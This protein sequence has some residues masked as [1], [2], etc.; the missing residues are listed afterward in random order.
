[1]PDAVNTFTRMNLDL[2]D[3]ALKPDVLRMAYNV[4]IVDLDSN[5]LVITNLKG[6]ESGFTIT[7]GFKAVAWKEYSEVLYLLSYNATTGATELGSYPSP[8]YAN[9]AAGQ[10]ATDPNVYFVYRPFNNLDNGPFST[11]LVG[12]PDENVKL[13]IQQ[14]YDESIN[15]FIISPADKPRMVNAGFR[16]VS[17]SNSAGF[18][19][20][21]SEDRPGDANTNQYVSATVEAQSRQ[22]ISS[23]KVL[24][25]DYDQILTGGKLKAGTYQYIF[26][27]LTED[28]NQSDV[29]GES[30]V[31]AVMP[32]TTAVDM[33][34]EPPTTDTE[35]MVRLDLSNIDTA[36][37][38]F[39]VWVRF[40]PGG[41]T[42]REFLYEFTDPL[43]ITGASMIFSHTG[44]ENIREVSFEEINID[45]PSVQGVKSATQLN[46]YMLLGGIK[47]TDQDWTAYKAAAQTVTV[48]V[49]NKAST[50]LSYNGLN[51]GY[52][53][54][55]NIY[56]SLAYFSAETYPFG[57]VFIM[58]SDM[59]LSP[60]FPVYGMDFTGKTPGSDHNTKGL[61]RFPMADA[62][63]YPI[64]ADLGGAEGM[65]LRYPVFDINNIPQAIRDQTVGFFFVRGQ[66][67]PDKITQG[68][69]LPTLK[70]PPVEYVNYEKYYYSQY[71]A[72]GDLSRYLHVPSV[73]GIL[74]AYKRDVTN[75]NPSEDIYAIINDSNDSNKLNAYMPIFI[76][77][78]FGDANPAGGVYGIDIFPSDYWAFLSGDAIAD[79]ARYASL[80]HRNSISVRQL[81]RTWFVRDGKINPVWDIPDTDTRQVGLYYRFSGNTFYPAEYNIQVDSKFTPSEILSTGHEFT[82]KIHN[83]FH[84]ATVGSSHY[85]FDV[86]LTYNPYFGLKVT[87][88]SFQDSSKV[89]NGPR[90]HASIAELANT[91]QT[92]GVWF[93][94]FGLTSMKGFMVDLYPRTTGMI[95]DINLLYPTVDDVV[96]RQVGKRYLWSDVPTNIVPVYGGDCYIGKVW[97]KLYQSGYRD[98]DRVYEGAEAPRNIDAGT[99]IS[100]VQESEYNLHMR[101]PYLYDVSEAEKRSFFPYQSH[102]DFYRYRRYRLPETTKAGL[103]FISSQHSKNYHK[104]DDQNI[105]LR[106]NF[107]S[108]VMH[109]N[110]HVPNSYANGYRRVVD[111]E[112]YDSSMGEIVDLRAHQGNLIIIFEHGVG[113]TSIEQ[114]I[115]TGSDAGGPIFAK[116]DTV[117]PPAIGYLSHTI[118]CQ[119]IKAI[120]QT[121]S[122]LYGIDRQKGKMW[123]IGV[124]QQGML[125]ISDMEIASWLENNSIVNPILGYD[126]RYREVILSTDNWAICFKEGVEHYIS[127]YGYSA[128]LYT[129][130][131]REFYSIQGA[132]ALRHNSST[133]FSLYGNDPECFVEF[134]INDSAAATKVLDWINILSNETRP[135][136]IEWFTYAGKSLRMLALNTDQMEQYCKVEDGDDALTGFA[137]IYFR[138]KKFV[139]KVPSVEIYNSLQDSWSASGRMRNRVIICRI[140]YNATTPLQLLA[141]THKY[142]ISKS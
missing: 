66:R 78:I 15:V 24:S 141:V 18:D 139:S 91:D 97:R 142:R 120:L 6:T 50:F 39:K 116:P 5:S 65:Y 30:S 46:G 109:T 94:N 38:Y 42:R 54:P 127:F 100:F 130:R 68:L 70:V 36:F 104:I 43:R 60:V 85:S 114:R 77:D 137:K 108:R 131:S 69:V 52:T 75:D 115:E 62:A 40:S 63:N 81:S 140:T 16:K 7:P 10:V 11:S 86:H 90:N 21:P 80:L 37:A 128:D 26:A 1:M 129:S 34:S 122:S 51:G 59:S 53:D 134:A 22:F 93:T 119:D 13:E 17:A 72:A 110:K 111:F 105:I 12:G 117:L 25:I 14:D 102:G 107:Y 57:I 20:I 35:K 112:D 133:S 49:P 84:Y 101:L 2:S 56:Y 83:R 19:L 67:R 89:S 82:S 58:K 138:D 32:G 136:K 3:Y 87:A 23:Q 4:R 47:Q 73:E 44:Y 55:Y 45:N 31:C 28:F 118:G 124:I 92:S 74:E 61:V 64:T 123:K 33:H 27:Y 79:E 106:N 9:Q 126:P 8:D 41:E 132:N 113:I 71:A 135:A 96:Y 121:P 95:S 99:L 48:S 103:G 76:N 98:P 29:I 125:P 88:G